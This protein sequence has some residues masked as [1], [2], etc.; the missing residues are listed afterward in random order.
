MLRPF[1]AVPLDFALH[2]LIFAPLGGCQK[3]DTLRTR[4][5]LERV[6]TFTAADTAQDK[7]DIP[8]R[9]WMHTS[10]SGVQQ[11]ERS[12]TKRE[13]VLRQLPRDLQSESR[14]H[15]LQLSHRS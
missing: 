4:R 8:S 7:S 10:L 9:T 1:S 6:S 14:G 15:A 13:V 12:K 3:R 11:R 2:L 5:E